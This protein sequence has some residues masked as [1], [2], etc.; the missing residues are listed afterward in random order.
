MKKFRF[1]LI[2]SFT[3]MLTLAACGGD[4][5]KTGS[6]SGDKGDRADQ[7]VLKAGH[8]LPEDHPYEKAFQE[9]ANNIEERTDGRV[10]IETFPNGQIGAERE[11]IE[12]LTQGTVDLVA[13]STA[14]MTNFV[15]E[16][17]VLDL[18][19]LFNDRQSAV[20]VLE[21]E[22]GDGLFEKIKGQ[23]I[24]PLSWGENGFRH[25]TNSKHQILEPKDLNGTK[26]RIEENELHLKAFRELGAEPTALEWEEAL[27][28]LRQGNVDA[29]ENPAFV[30]DQFNVYDAGQKYM[31]LTGHVYSVV[32]FMM[33]QKT[34]DKL[35]EDVRDIIVEEGQNIGSFERDYIVELE[36]ESMKALE[37]QGMEIAKE[38]DVKLF[39]DAMKS[40]YDSYKDQEMLN[41]IRETQQ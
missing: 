33:S 36:Q 3:F 28:A 11:L 6:D 8:S 5:E 41:K 18:P 35:P 4:K 7:I 16:L 40:V 32:I 1:A 31:S 20:K 27:T 25:M 15:P 39:Q 21:G 26:I 30:A 34:Y 38:V 13:A 9:M 2:L 17:E 10:K 22:I 24:L 37:N 12:K 14:S 23:G 19:F 29:Q